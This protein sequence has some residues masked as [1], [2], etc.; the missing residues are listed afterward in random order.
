[1]QGSRAMAFRCPWLG[2]RPVGNIRGLQAAG[3]RLGFARHGVRRTAPEVYRT[4][5][6]AERAL[7]AMAENGS[8]DCD[9]DRRYRA[10]VLLATF[11][12]LRWGEATALKRCD[13]DLESGV[14]RVRAAFSDRRSPV[15]RLRSALTTKPGR[16]SSR[17]RRPHVDHVLDLEF[18]G[19]AGEG[20]RTLMTSLEGWGS[21]IELR[22][23]GSLT[24]RP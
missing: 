21:T 19:G 12:S 16:L 8:A 4:R 1:M 24:V 3:Y 5:A 10:P 11:A 13:L 22:P 9:Y 17:L 20:N 2:R 18:C 6:D 14:V 15:A 23:R 7:W